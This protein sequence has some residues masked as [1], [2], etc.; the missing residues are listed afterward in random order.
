MIRCVPVK[1]LRY[2]FRPRWSGRVRRN[3]PAH[4]AADIH[5][6]HAPALHRGL[7]YGGRAHPFRE[8]TL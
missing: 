4:A 2:G 8:E 7:G 1:S 3:I 6:C 5:H